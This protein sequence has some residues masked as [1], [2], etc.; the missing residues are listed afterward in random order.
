MYAYASV[1]LLAKGLTSTQIGYLIAAGS[2]LSVIIQ[3]ILGAFADRSKK[4]ILHKLTVGMFLIMIACFVGLFV[5]EN[6]NSTR[7]ILYAILIILLQATTSLTYSLGLFFIDMGLKVNIGI[8]RGMGSLFY[9][10]V[11]SILGVLVVN[12]NEDVIVIAGI[13]AFVLL[14]LSIATFH[15]KGVKEV[16]LFKSEENGK[17]RENLSLTE[18][19]ATHKRYTWVLIGNTFAF[20]AYNYLNSYMFQIVSFHGGTE[21][22]M[23][24]AISLGA[25]LELP[26]LF[27]LTLV[28]RKLRSGL[29]YKVSAVVILLKC[30]L[31]MTA[32]NMGMIYV[33]MFT[34][35]LGYGLYAGI[36]IYYIA[37]TIE[38][39]EQVR[40]QALMTATVTVGMLVGSGTGGLLIDK[41]SVPA[42]L[43]AA[44]ITALIGAIIICVSAEKGNLQGKAEEA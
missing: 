31:F 35:A 34:Q 39:E 36:S 18:F 33:A 28:N 8:A 2:G 22:D 42:L 37:N 43:I 17:T 7:V 26:I 4:P 15:F 12:F 10:A 16:K 14:S 44:V 32:M 6:S 24:F 9:A 11:S 30:V 3:P 13:I 40:G 20:I 5:V 21:K 23:G 29:L 38:N 25:F 1:Y 27:T 19:F 41:G